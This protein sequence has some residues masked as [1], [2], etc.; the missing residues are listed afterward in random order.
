MMALLMYMYVPEDV[1]PKLAFYTDQKLCF[2]KTLS[3][4]N[5]KQILKLMHT[6][7][8]NKTKLDTNKNISWENC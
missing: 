5:V 1:L 6:T 2:I 4:R 7:H 8:W 3:V